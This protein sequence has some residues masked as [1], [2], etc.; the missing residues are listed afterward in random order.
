M[1]EILTVRSVDRRSRIEFDLRTLTM[2]TQYD[3]LGAKYEV[4]KSTPHNI[5]CFNT[6]RRVLG[7][8]SGLRVLDLAC[9]TGYYST[10]F[11][12]WGAKSVVGIDLSAEMVREANAALAQA[13]QRKSHLK[14]Y[15][16]DVSQ[17]DLL[18]SLNLSDE[19]FDLVHGAWLL[20][21]ASTASELTAMWHTIAAALEPGGR[22]V[23]LGPNV[24][25]ANFGFDAPWGEEKYGVTF[26]PIKKV[27]HGYKA[28]IKA[29]T[30]TP[31]E[32]ENYILN[33]KGFYEKCA[34]EGGMRDLRF[35]PVVP[36][37]EDIS[38]YEDGFWDEYS[39]RPRAAICIATR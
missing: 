27:E 32:F 28:H 4:I 31:V 1:L 22:F 36:E 13:P 6:T 25:D 2:S 7:D 37:T 38:K 39:K 11:L 5:V 8:V 33:E 16:G 9:G 24:A 19:K 15:V 21:Y 23:G 18:R 30:A 35:E 26:M 34:K 17:P 14:Y 29:F 20:N 10:Y 3:D 12:D